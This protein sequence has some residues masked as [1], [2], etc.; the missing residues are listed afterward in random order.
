L[1]SDPSEPPGASPQHAARPTGDGGATDAA[2]DPT[3]GDSTPSG[4][5]SSVEGERRPSPRRWH[6]QLIAISL[7]GLAL[8]VGY[9]YLYRR[10]APP[11]GDAFFYHYQANLLVS[12]KWFINPYQY[13]Y[14]R[15]VV[16]A[17]DHPPLWTLVLALASLVGIKSFFAQILWSC[18]VGSVAVW[19]VGL[20]G[21][22][23]AGP[24][25]GLIAAGI[26]AVYPNFWI[27]D[28]SLLSETLV[29]TLTALIVWTFYR[30]WNH[31]S[32]SRAA[33]LGCACA[34]DALA[35]SELVLLVP[36]FVIAAG[37]LVRNQ[38]IRRRL[39]LSVIAAT[40]AGLTLVPWYAYNLTRF[41]DSVPLSSQLGVTL[42]TANCNTTYYGKLLGYWS[43][44]CALRVHTTKGADPSVQDHE[45][46]EAAIKYAEHHESRLPV[47]VAA[48]LGRELDLYR[49]LQ[50][51]DLEWSILGRPRL[52]AY[53]GMGAY[54]LCAVLAVAGIVVLRRRRIVVTPFVALIAVTL[55]VAAATFG[56]TRYRTAL[57]AAIVILAAVA[58]GQFASPTGR[59]Q[60]RG[61]HSLR[62]PTVPIPEPGAGDHAA[63]HRGAPYVPDTVGHAPNQ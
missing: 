42:A 60:P 21:R 51:V 36:I 6:L 11:T 15:H 32:L 56:Q 5:V 20:A 62:P 16:P 26:A 35:R 40:A 7:V 52:P 49:P 10:H 19:L 13:F 22:E 9:V 41:S 12:G 2:H 37:L 39:A 3:A 14:F 44:E 18:V 33:W 45:Y 53:V 63:S 47:V 17:A 58:I 54:Y 61:K 59:R 50:Q 8:R 4:D 28:G 29:L 48:R 27:N 30:L 38:R 23:I 25:T 34:L 57:D 24:R 46:R 31:P 55:F 1:P 43:L